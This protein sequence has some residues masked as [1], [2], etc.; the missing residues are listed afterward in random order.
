V[1]RPTVTD[2]FRIR[3]ILSQAGWAGGLEVIGIGVRYALV[4][5]IARSL[6]AAGLGLYTLAIA[7]GSAAA[8]AGRIGLDRASMRFTAFHRA[9]GERGQA[10][11][12]VLFSSVVTACLSGVVGVLLFIFSGPLETAWSQPQLASALRLTAIAVPGIALG[13]V[14]RD[15][16][17]GF[18]DVRLASVLE[19]AVIPGATMLVALVLVVLNPGQPLTAIGAAAAAYWLAAL[20]AGVALRRDVRSL[21]ARP[22]YSPGQ[23][24]GFAVFLSLEGGLLFLLQWSDQLLV[25]LFMSAS[26]VGIYA[27]AIRVAA[28]A[29]VPLL[30]VNS[31][32]APTVAA[33]YGGGE[34]E[35]LRKTYSRL[36]WATG[37]IGLGIGLALIVFGAGLLGLFGAEFEAG[38]PALAI[39]TVGHIVNSATGSAGLVLGMTGHV[40]WRLLNA[41]LTAVLNVVLNVLLIPPLGI[42]GSALA[43]SAAL[44]VINLLQICEVRFVLGFWGYDPAQIGF[45]IHRLRTLRGR[46]RSESA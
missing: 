16:L 32:L 4:V 46:L 34:L 19:K 23:W 3:Y 24:L 18:Q 27:A 22:E 17:R 7:F 44:I 33:L 9:R 40:R 39:V 28:L 21:A 30:A 42:V 20:I 26:D 12:V 25:G 13:E 41:A 6:G 10:A 1:S 8:L 2:A 43:T 29:A 14:W 15:A 5:V 31:I 37:A 36:T 35:G 38:Y 11:G 45:W